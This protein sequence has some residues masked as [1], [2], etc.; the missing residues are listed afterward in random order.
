MK[1]YGE[2]ELLLHLFITLVLFGGKLTAFI[3]GPCRSGETATV[4][5]IE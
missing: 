5:I 3:L 4:V 2:L 1:A